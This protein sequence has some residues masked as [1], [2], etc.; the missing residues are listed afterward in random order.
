MLFSSI[1][2]MSDYLSI[3]TKK[4]KRINDTLKTEDIKH[5]QLC[6]NCKSLA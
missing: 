4:V 6:D 5:I 3:C 2:K 1:T